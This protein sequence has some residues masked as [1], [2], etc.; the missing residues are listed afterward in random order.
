MDKKQTP[1]ELRKRY[2]EA[3]EQSIAAFPYQSIEVEGTEALATW[4][5]LRVTHPGSSP[6][7]VGGLEEFKRIVEGATAWPGRPAHRTPAQ[8]I[9]IADRLH[10]PEDL[11][12]QHERDVA[13]MRERIEQ[14]KRERP[15]LTPPPKFQLPDFIKEAFGGKFNA[16]SGDEMIESTRPWGEPHIGEWPTEPMG[17]PK[18]SVATETLS[19]APL[20]KVQILILPTDESSTIPAY[21][22]WGHWNGCPAPEYHIAALRSWR[23]RFGAE[24]VG[25]SHD[26]MNL[27][28]Q[29]KPPTREAAIE[30]AREQY[31]YC[32]DIVDQ[33]VQ[34][35]SALAA[36][37]MESDWWYFWWD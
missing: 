7:V 10:H 8:I 16:M 35:L 18:L 21:L 22:H 1:E 28:V 19:G 11:Y 29:S 37:L 15:D 4:E 13:E 30:L 17:A 34:T 14:L 5:R 31:V 3:V 33:G 32:S 25:L 12:R 2:E 9:E 36:V 24:L 20:E 26:V 27:R 6:V 23:E